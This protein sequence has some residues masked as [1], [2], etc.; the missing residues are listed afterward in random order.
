[1]DAK[2][3]SHASEQGP[4]VQ[5][6]TVRRGLLIGVVATAGA[7]ALFTALPAW[8][9][10]VTPVV[11]RGNPSCPAGTT[12]L[13]VEPV[14]DGTFTDGTLTVNLDV[15]GSIF[16]WASNIGVDQ[17][18]VK[19]GPNANVY[20][21]PLESTGDTGLSAPINPAN[22]QPYGLSHVSFCY[23]VETP[24]PTTTTTSPTPTPTPTSPTPT[25][26]SP[27]TTP[28]TTSTPTP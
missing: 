17:V 28:S 23:D 11:V 7:A 27:T 22:G 10:S 1:M 19:G 15:T 25:P 5:R 26:T 3:T 9:A 24:P 16:D 8:G 12:T 20:T 2:Q 6:R 18:I 13:K 21:Y 14:S 4:R